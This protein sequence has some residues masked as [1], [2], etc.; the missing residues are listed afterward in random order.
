M[1]RMEGDYVGDEEKLEVLKYKVL[2]QLSIIFT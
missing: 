2:T 1:D